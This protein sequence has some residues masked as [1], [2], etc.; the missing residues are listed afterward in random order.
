MPQT[1]SNLKSPRELN[2]NN[3]VKKSVF[4]N[5]CGW[6]EGATSNSLLAPF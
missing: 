2:L 1:T 3:H 4:L 5:M 6:Q